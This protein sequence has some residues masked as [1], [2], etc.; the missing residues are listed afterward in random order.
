MSG[1]KRYRVGAIAVAAAVGLW[2]VALRAGWAND[3]WTADWSPAAE[4][5]GKPVYLQSKLVETA[6]EKEKR[7]AEQRLGLREEAGKLKRSLLGDRRR[8]LGE[9]IVPE[10]PPL[11]AGFEYSP[12]EACLQVKLEYPERFGKVDCMSDQFN[13][14]DPWWTVGAMGQ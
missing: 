9:D 2:G 1:D 5:R 8:M 3:A 4:T 7:L 6:Q 14:P 12:R 13:N 11:P 10:A